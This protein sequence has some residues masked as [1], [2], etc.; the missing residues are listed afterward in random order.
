MTLDENHA[1][2]AVRVNTARFFVRRFAATLRPV[3]KHQPLTGGATDRLVHL[4]I[5]TVPSSEPKDT[6]Q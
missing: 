3:I 2:Q 5:A 1:I 4:S 6:Q